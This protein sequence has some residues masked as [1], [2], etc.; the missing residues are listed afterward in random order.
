MTDREE[1][2]KLR[3]RLY[4]LADRMGMKLVIIVRRKVYPEERRAASAAPAKQGREPG[5]E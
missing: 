4:A 2:E 3:K 1:F 5:E